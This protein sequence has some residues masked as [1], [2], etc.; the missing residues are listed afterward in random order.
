MEFEKAIDEMPE[1]VLGQIAA[2]MPWSSAMGEDVNVVD[3][4]GFAISSVSNYA[5][6]SKLQK[7]CWEKFLDN[8]QINSH[9]RDY[10]GNLTGYGFSMDSDIPEIAT[11]MKSTIEDP[12]NALYRNMSKFVARSEIE[13]ELFLCLTVHNDGFV[14]VDFMSPRSLTASGY[15]QSGIYYHSEKQNFPLFYEFDLADDSKNPTIIPSIN[16]AYFPELKNYA[17]K[18]F[19]DIKPDYLK[20]S[21]NSSRKFSKVGNFKR[22][23]VEWDKGFLTTRNV[24]HLR[25]TIIWINHYENLKKWEIDHKK[26]SGS[27]L[28]VASISD[29]KAFRTWLKMTEDQKKDTGLFAKKKPGGTIVLPPGITLEC[30]N[31]NLA[32]ISDADTDIMGMVIS[33]LNR[34]EDMVTGATKG[35]TFSGVNASRGPQ[36]DRIQDQI[37][38]FEKFLRY[39]FWRPIF[40]LKSIVSNFKITYKVKEVIEFKDKEPIVKNVDKDVHDLIYIEFPVSEVTDLVGKAS[41]LL[42][43]KHP[44]LV[45]TLGIPREDVAKKLG[46]GNYRK[47]RLQLATEDEKFPKLLSTV[48]AESLQQASGEVNPPNN[49]PGKPPNNT[50]PTDKTEKEQAPKNKQQ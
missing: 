35:S 45:E 12:R 38:Y 20:S 26:S 6:F 1:D 43:V 34:P 46:F 48:E 24:S 18:N 49:N 36:A 50:P 37:A 28:W 32:R 8:P 15:K 39:D 31:P 2:S 16:I 11:E 7:M 13:G 17:L 5:D 19:K 29:A 41:A 44:S 27:Y 40:Y 3:E 4:E 21:V 10:M 47:K 42:G 9:V 30:K 33:G 14:E 22:F 25:T 23:I